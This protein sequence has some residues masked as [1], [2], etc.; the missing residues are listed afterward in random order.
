MTAP[1]LLHVNAPLDCG[2][3]SVCLAAAR[4]HDAAVVSFLT[5]LGSDVSSGSDRSL[6]DAVLGVLVDEDEDVHVSV[7][8]PPAGH[9]PFTP[10]PPDE[11][12]AVPFLTLA[13]ADGGGGRRRRY[14]PLEKAVGALAVGLVV[15]NNLLVA[16]K[17][18]HVWL[19]CA[20]IMDIND[21]GVAR[22]K[23]ASTRGGWDWVPLRLGPSGSGSACAASA[24][25]AFPAHRVV[26][27][28]EWPDAARRVRQHDQLGG[29]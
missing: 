2:A 12:E 17:G 22:H 9:D 21:R 23:A 20:A 18:A 13:A 8:V 10:V 14:Y 29:G 5:P 4:V 28:D 24:A 19:H 27:L 15:W 25:D 7:L 11:Y 1:L 26:E 16:P 6:W 3:A